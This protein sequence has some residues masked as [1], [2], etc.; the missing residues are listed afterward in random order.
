MVRL[1]GNGLTDHGKHYLLNREN[2]MQP[3]LR[4]LSQ[5]QKAF[6][7]FF[8]SFVKST[9]NFIYFP[10]RNYPDSSCISEFKASEKRREINVYKV[11]FQRTLRQT[12]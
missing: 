3:I 5:K 9:L 7:I 2:L 4:E 6:S 11:V 1:F 12:T 8:F 10:I